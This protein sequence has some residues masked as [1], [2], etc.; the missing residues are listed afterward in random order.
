MRTGFGVYAGREAVISTISHT[1]KKLACVQKGVL[2][3]QVPILVT[4][5]AVGQFHSLPYLRAV[6]KNNRD[7]S[8]PASAFSCGFCYV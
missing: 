1:S 3:V 2:A 7:R 8:E 6:A 5:V 4:V